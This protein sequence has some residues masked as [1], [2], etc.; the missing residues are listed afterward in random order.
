MQTVCSFFYTPSGCLKGSTCSFQHV[1]ICPLRTNCDKGAMCWWPHVANDQELKPCSNQTCPRKTLLN[2]K[3]CKPCYVKLLTELSEKVPT[4]RST[5]KKCNVLECTNTTTLKFCKQCYET[6]KNKSQKKTITTKTN[7]HTRNQTTRKQST[8]SQRILLTPDDFP[9]LPSRKASVQQQ[10]HVVK[11]DKQTTPLVPLVPSNQETPHC[12]SEG[13]IV[14]PDL[15][16]PLFY[17]Q[18]D[19]V[20]LDATNIHSLDV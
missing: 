13:P 5:K 9:E 17:Q 6:Q 1:Q 7:S 10:Q 8:K 11:S 19:S 18:Y 12:V 15:T 16:H 2:R 4:T 14:I 20:Q 3:Y